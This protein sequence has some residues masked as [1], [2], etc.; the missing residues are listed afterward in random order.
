MNS[1]DLATDGTGRNMTDTHSLPA[2]INPEPLIL[3]NKSRLF[4]KSTGDSYVEEKKIKIK[5]FAELYEQANKRTSESNQGEDERTYDRAD[6]QMNE[7]T[8]K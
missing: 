2:F 4:L 5:C 6:A 7:G 3:Y 8:D 1:P